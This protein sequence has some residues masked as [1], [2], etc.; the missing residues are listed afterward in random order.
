MARARGAAERAPPRAAR[1]RR[2]LEPGGAGGRARG[3]GPPRPGDRARWPARAEQPGERDLGR[4]GAA[5]ARGGVGQ[6]ARGGP[7]A[8]GAAR[9]AQRRVRDQ[10]D[11]ELLAA[12]DQPA[13]QRAVVVDAQR[14][15]DGGDRRELERLVELV[16]V[17]V[18]QPDARDQALVEQPGERADRGAP[19]RAGIGRV[20]Q[21]EVDRQAAE[22]G[23]GSPRSRRRIALARPSGTQPPPGRVIPPLV[24]I[25]AREAAPRRLSARA[26]SRSLWPSSVVTAA[27]CARGVEHGDAGLER[28]G[29]RLAGELLVAVGLGRQAHAAEADA[30]LRGVE[31]GGRVRPQS[32]RGRLGRRCS[33]RALR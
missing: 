14:D 27:V 8:G 22:R 3:L 19:R 5:R 11:A 24:T 21:V 7:S 17:D 10:R 33:A 18:G 30:E 25:R 20:D 6:R 4:G 9:A 13:A 16:A 26:S 31:P 12:L 2:E 32:V 28:G 15:L 23:S 1:S 29:D